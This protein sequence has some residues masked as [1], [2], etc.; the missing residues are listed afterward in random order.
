M[1]DLVALQQSRLSCVEEL[2][3]RVALFR[4]NAVKGLTARLNQ[5]RPGRPSQGLL[6]SG[7]KD[8]VEHEEAIL[9]KCGN[10]GDAANEAL[11]VLADISE[12]SLRDAPLVWLHRTSV[13]RHDRVVGTQPVLIGDDSRR[14]ASVSLAIGR[15]HRWRRLTTPLAALVASHQQ[16]TCCPNRQGIR[17]HV[18]AERGRGL[19][20]SAGY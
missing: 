15:F 12:H 19:L 10:Q 16:R 8:A 5:S 3:S 14:L 2:D 9:E 13:P 4:T 17:T 11:E 18:S 20:R 6:R 1:D 7:C